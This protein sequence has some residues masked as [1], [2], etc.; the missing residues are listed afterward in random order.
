MKYFFPDSQDFV[1]PNFDF[2][3]EKNKPLRVTQRDDV[4][5]H[6]LLERP[7]DGLLIS[8]AIVEGIPGKTDKTRYSRG[9][10]YRLFREGAHRFFRLT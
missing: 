4:Y 6:H 5:A 9:Q 7:Y 3:T 8:K 10:K 2:E 1:D